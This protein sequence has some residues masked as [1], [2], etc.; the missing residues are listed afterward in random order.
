MTRTAAV[1][2][3]DAGA[4]TAAL[5]AAGLVVTGAA[6]D[7][8]VTHGGDGTLLRAERIWPGVP[9]VPVR[10]GARARLCGRHGLEA[11]VAGLAADA[12]EATE[13]P[14]IAVTFGGY[15][16][17]ALNDVVMRNALPTEAVR[18]R[19]EQEGW[20]S[21]EITGDGLVIATPFGST[22]YY[23]SITR[24]RV[25]RGLGVAFNNT[26]EVLEP[27]ELP[28]GGQVDVQVL[29]GPAVLVPDNDVR[30]VPLRAGHRFTVADS[31][32]RAVVLG[33][34]ALTCGDCRKGDGAAFNPH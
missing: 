8:V 3:D 5:E 7:V 21:G 15:R 34:D 16:A 19:V 30:A 28:D 23:R 26:T 31:L 27:L 18:F 11:V 9:K 20:A 6:P 1:V 4:V 12:L 10:I 32:E 22:A 25:E 29:R 33:L 2:G 17:L 13:L 14:K 24:R